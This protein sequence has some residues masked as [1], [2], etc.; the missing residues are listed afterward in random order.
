VA[1]L[2]QA[3]LR[4][5]KMQMKLGLFDPKESQPYFNYGID[6][7]DSAEHQSLALDAAKQAIVL[8]K[9]EGGVLPIKPGKRV[10]VVGPHMDATVDLISNYHGS[11]CTC[12]FTRSLERAPPSFRNRGLLS[13][14]NLL[15]HM[16]SRSVLLAAQPLTT[17]F[18][19][20]WLCDRRRQQV[21]L[22]RDT[23]RSHH[24]DECRG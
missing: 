24:K 18:A 4:L 22:H 9:N 15:L 14:S 12:R 1:A 5:T 8:L 20:L 21:R 6:K 19:P 13:K 3:L 23:I 10:A 7:I 11:R 16:R 17:Q 2:D